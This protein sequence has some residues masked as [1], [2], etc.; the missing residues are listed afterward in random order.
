MTEIYQNWTG[1]SRKEE[2][3]I[4]YDSLDKT[5]LFD[6]KNMKERKGHGLRRK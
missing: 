3:S 1:L 5:F 4:S 2:N 6:G